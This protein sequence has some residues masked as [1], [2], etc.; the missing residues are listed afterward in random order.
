[1]APCSSLP[2]HRLVSKCSPRNCSGFLF[3]GT[4]PSGPASGTPTHQ[5]AHS[6]CR[7]LAQ[8][9]N[10][11]PCSP[12]DLASRLILRS[13]P[14]LSP[15]IPELLQPWPLQGPPL[16]FPSLLPHTVQWSDR[17]EFRLII[18]TDTLAL[19]AVMVL[20]VRRLMLLLPAGHTSLMI[21]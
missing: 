3:L 15:Y 7:L 14:T 6:F 11:T 10:L 2:A 18:R 21:R 20:C 9:F 5:F 8:H 4:F 12:P 19:Q 13:L 17:R 1:M 16:L